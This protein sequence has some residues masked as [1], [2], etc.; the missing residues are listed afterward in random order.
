MVTFFF[1]L[2]KA[3]MEKEICCYILH[4]ATL[5]KFYIGACQENLTERIKKHNTKFYDGKNFTKA[6]SDW[7]LF[8]KIKASDFSQAVRIERK[9]KAMKSSKYINNLLKYPELIIKLQSL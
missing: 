5:N 4:S 7:T 3:F 1:I 8:I 9:I 6:A 2:P